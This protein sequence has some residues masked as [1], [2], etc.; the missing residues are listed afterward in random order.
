MA[1]EWRGHSVEGD[2]K[3]PEMTAKTD[4]VI[5]HGSSLAPSFEHAFVSDV[6]RHGV[7]SCEPD[8]SLRDVAR[9][10]AS[11]HIHAVVVA[12]DEDGWGVISSGDLLQ[13]AGTERERYSAGEVAA[14]EFVSVQAAATLEEA[15]QLMREHEVEHTVVVDAARRPVG[16]LSTLDIAGTLAWGEA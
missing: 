7:I 2:R 12:L 15:A 10:M 13:T 14:T 3:E 4:I 8:A 6:M 9:I 11:Y 1:R 16:M 5:A